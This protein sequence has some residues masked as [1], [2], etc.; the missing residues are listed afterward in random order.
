V[1]EKYGMDEFLRLIDKTGGKFITVEVNVPSN[2]AV[3]KKD[4]K[5]TV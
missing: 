2:S 3:E 4:G 5:I 1:P